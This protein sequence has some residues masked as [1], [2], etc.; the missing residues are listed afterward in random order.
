MDLKNLAI[1]PVTALKLRSKLKITG[2]CKTKLMKCMVKKTKMAYSE[3]E[4]TLKSVQVSCCTVL[5]Y[6]SNSIIEQYE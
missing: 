5:L 6:K 1:L 2:H 3:P 4:A